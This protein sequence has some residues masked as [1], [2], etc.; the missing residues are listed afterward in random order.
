MYINSTEAVI[1]DM[2]GTLLDSMEIWTE[3][4]RTFLS[5][6]GIAYDN[7]VSVA[8]KKLHFNSACEYLKNYF[9]LEMSVTEI[10]ERIMEIVRHSYLHEVSLKP[11]V[12]EYISRLK[13]IGVKMCVA[14]SNER[15]L[16]VGALE[17]LGIYGDMEFVITSDEIGEGK[18]NPKIFLEA[19][20]R[21]EKFPEDIYVFEDSV[22]ALLSAKVAGFHTVGVYEKRFADEFTVL[23][24]DAE[25]TIRGFYELIL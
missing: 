17:N 21:F 2:D 18:E 3:A 8:L 6:L 9:S 19:A 25:F 16:A 5:G 13:S 1:F 20:K 22:H 14:T 10:G 4:D 11:Y 12:R 23:Q 7:S 15:S 24:R